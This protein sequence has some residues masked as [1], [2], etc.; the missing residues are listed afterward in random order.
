[1]DEADLLADHIAVLA[2][3]GKLVAQGSP[4]ALK[5]EFGKGY[6]VQVTFDAYQDPEKAT[7][8]RNDPYQRLLT[9]IGHH[10]ETTI[11]SPLQI[12]YHLNTRD[13]Q[14]VADVLRFLNEEKSHYCIKSYD[15]LGTSMEDIFLS[16]MN[17]NETTP[18]V[19]KRSSKDTPVPTSEKCEEGAE[20]GTV[21]LSSL[22]HGQHPHI[23]QQ[24]TT[25]FYKRFLILRRSWLSPFLTVLVAVMG[26]TIPLVFIDKGAQT[27]TQPVLDM[28]I[29]SLYLPA[30]SFPPLAAVDVLD[31][32]PGIVSSL[33][34][35]TSSLILDNVPNNATFVNTIYSNY[36]NISA[37]GVSI[38]LT[39][40]GSLVA[41]E[42]S[43]PGS[44]GPSMLNLA[45]NILYNR[46]LNA[47][48]RQNTP[49]IISPNYQSLPY[50]SSRSLNSLKWVGFYGATMVSYELCKSVI[51]LKYL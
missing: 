47:S 13:T 32:P 24:A 39:T 34:N 14:V 31:S 2:A 38:D 9:I 12:L 22:S 28:P 33:G 21:L 48:G 30:T 8:P 11:I 43:P 27:C 50:P 44:M 20:T 1:M 49:T 15:V 35:T 19:E 29:V 4:V 45:T 26:S 6:N 7:T 36:R 25:I 5:H 3:P 37:G 23:F 41:W 42:A 16:L 10:V 40:G 46:A 18:E 51:D 17:K